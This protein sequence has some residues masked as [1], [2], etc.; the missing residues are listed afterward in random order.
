MN[1]KLR[2]S[3]NN[4]CLLK[5]AS[6]FGLYSFNTFLHWT[7]RLWTPQHIWRES[8]GCDPSF[9][10][11]NWYWLS[12]CCLVLVVVNI[13]PKS[14]HACEKARNKC[15]FSL[16][17]IWNFGNFITRVFC[18]KKTWVLVQCSKYFIDRSWVDLWSK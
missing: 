11:I 12:I 5:R 4:L 3:N 13:Q 15:F 2:K 1:K 9:T 16:T 10:C 17:W 6:V 14:V 8:A 18:Y 7:W